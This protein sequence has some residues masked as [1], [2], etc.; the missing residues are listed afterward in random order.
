MAIKITRLDNKKVTEGVWTEYLGVE[1][2]IARHNN[3]AYLTALKLEAEKIGPKP[4]HKLPQSVRSSIV[5]KAMAE[6]ILVDWRGLIVEGEEVEYSPANALELLTND[7]E[8][9]SFVIDF[10]MNTMHFMLEAE[11]VTGES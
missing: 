3:L 5:M 1:L 9:L 11:Q 8:C 2:C 10:A 7:E 6:H 4:L